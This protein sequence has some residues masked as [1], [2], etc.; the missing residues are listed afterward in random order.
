MST[1]DLV[2]PELRAALDQRP[3]LRLGPDILAKSRAFVLQASAAEA[4][5]NLPDIVA[6]EVRVK[7]QFDAPA[8]RVLT[9]RPVAAEGLSPAILHVHGGGFVMGAP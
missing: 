8:I 6:D 9:Y 3:K 7:S 1:R 2:D 4:K 5:P